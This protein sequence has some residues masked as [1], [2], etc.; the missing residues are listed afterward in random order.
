MSTYF[1]AFGNYKPA[2]KTESNYH[3]VNGS[4]SKSIPAAELPET[5]FTSWYP[6]ESAAVMH[7]SN[8]A[9]GIAASMFYSSNLLS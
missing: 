9:R 4:E 2:Q 6:E 8:R 5:I 3:D 1:A 7:L